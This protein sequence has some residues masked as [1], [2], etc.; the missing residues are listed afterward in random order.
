MMPKKIIGLVIAT[1]SI[2]VSEWYFHSY[3]ITRYEEF[4]TGEFWFGVFF[5]YLFINST[6][7]YLFAKT[8]YATDVLSHLGFYSIITFFSTIVIFYILL[9]SSMGKIGG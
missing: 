3:M 1:I 6:L 2:A 8:K 5:I 4:T 7:A 9:I